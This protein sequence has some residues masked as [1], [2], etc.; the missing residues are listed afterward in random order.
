MAIPVRGTFRYVAVVPDNFP[1][2]SAP[3]VAALREVVERTGNELLDARLVGYSPRVEISDAGIT[4]DS[5]LRPGQRARPRVL[6]S[7]IRLAA[8]ERKGA[9]ASAVSFHV[10]GSLISALRPRDELHMSRTSCGG[11]GLSI[12]RNG[13]L[14]AGVG[15]LTA[16]PLGNDVRVSVPEDLITDAEA[17]FR[18]RDPQ[19]QFPEL[20]IELSIGGCRHVVFRGWIHLEGYEVFMEHGFYRGIP[21]RNECLAISLNG[22]CS[23]TAAN[24]SAQLLDFPDVLQFVEW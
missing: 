12:V 7:Q 10:D 21:G 11:L 24:A 14:I 13:Q 6:R 19:F 9:T 23:V 5:L 16:V 17:V 18:R 22:A 1:D 8:A 15:A 2:N 3:W 4:P 20:P